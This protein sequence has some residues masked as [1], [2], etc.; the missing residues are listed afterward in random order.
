MIAIYHIERTFFETC[1]LLNVHSFH[2]ERGTSIKP[3]H[4][5][6]LKHI[7][8][9]DDFE[10]DLLVISHKHVLRGMH[11]QKHP[12]GQGKLICCV[13]GAAKDVI[14]DI[15]KN[16]DT[17]GAH[18][19][20]ELSAD[21]P[22]VIYIPEGFAH[23]YLSTMND[24]LIYYKMTCEYAPSF[25][26]GIRWDSLGIHWGIDAPIVSKRDNGFGTLATIK[27]E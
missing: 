3:F 13:R 9:S 7:G 22:Q 15:R 2:D 8:I 6:S 24:T 19:V 11:F 17:F 1:L 12:K 27:L 14:V 20:I 25:E 10:E 4:S 16:S 18:E 5:K 23:G 21:V 26:S